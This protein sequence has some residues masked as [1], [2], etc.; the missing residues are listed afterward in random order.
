MCSSDLRLDAKPIRWDYQEE[1]ARRRLYE[2]Y[3]GLLQLRAHPT[4]QHNFL[5]GTVQR[6][7]TG[8]LKWVQLS[9]DSAHLVVVG[10]FDINPISGSVPF[11]L[12]GSWTDYFTGTRL[13]VA[14]PTQTVSLQ[15][16]EYRIYLDRNVTFPLNAVTPVREL[17]FPNGIL[18]CK[19]FPNPAA[20][21]STVE[22][23]LPASGKISLQMFSAQGR[24]VGVLEF[25][26]VKGKYALPLAALLSPTQPAGVYFLQMK[27]GQAIVGQKVIWQ[28]TSQ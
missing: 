6:S 16:G 7:L 17:S 15:P 13:E 27:F 25:F 22:Y 28:R 23:E 18:K 2:V 11:P 1:P 12:T 4:F 26:K 19:V 3:R 20:V 8:G 5:V 24:E 10:N 9:T 21:N 14:A